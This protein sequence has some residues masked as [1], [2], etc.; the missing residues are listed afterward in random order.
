MQTNKHKSTV[1]STFFYS[2]IF[3]YAKKYSYYS[4]VVCWTSTISH[5][6]SRYWYFV[7]K[8]NKNTHKKAY[9]Q[10]I[11]LHGYLSMFVHTYLFIILQ[12]PTIWMYHKLFNNT[13]I[14]EYLG[15]PQFVS[16]WKNKAIINTNV[17]LFGALWCTCG[18]ILFYLN[19]LP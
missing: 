12:L 13:S 2:L 3:L 15:F 10:W 9:S 14:Y 6:S 17:N 11:Y 8:Q 19:I 18:Y 1:V 7:S 4:T 5:C 16:C